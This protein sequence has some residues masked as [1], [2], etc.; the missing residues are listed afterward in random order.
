MK[1]QSTSNNFR[2][3]LWDNY[4]TLDLC[5]NVVQRME[6]GDYC[7]DSRYENGIYFRTPSEA[8]KAK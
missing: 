6:R 7:D 4:Y 8:K 1:T 2:A 5:G 3:E